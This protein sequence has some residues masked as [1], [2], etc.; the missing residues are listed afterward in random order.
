MSGGPVD[1]TA[2]AASVVAARCATWRAVHA[3]GARRTLK[4]RPSR[5]A[6]AHRITV[7]HVAAEAGP[8][9]VHGLTRL[10]TS[11]SASPAT[12]YNAI[13]KATAPAEYS[14]FLSIS[15][16]AT[17]VVPPHR[18]H[19]NLWTKVSRNSG[20]PP[21]VAGPQACLPRRPCPCSTIPPPTG[22]L[23]TRQCGHRAGLNSSA[24][25]LFSAHPLTSS[26]LEMMSCLPCVLS[27]TAHAG[28]ELGRVASRPAHL[29]SLSCAWWRP[30]PAP[31]HPL[32]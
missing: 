19:L 28:L 25:G 1:G 31:S 7:P 26:R 17:V 22:R 16:G 4:S 27:L 21:G 8:T 30:P 13:A 11:A 15:R 6:S 24:V 32:T 10:R 2:L 12:P 3:S 18:L 23:A 5:T 20:L 14:R 9:C 29:L